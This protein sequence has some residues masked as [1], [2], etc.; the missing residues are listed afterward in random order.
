MDANQ[1]QPRIW[2]MQDMWYTTH[3]VPMFYLAKMEMFSTLAKNY[4]VIPTTNIS[5]VNS[6][7]DEG[8]AGL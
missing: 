1:R 8:D 7:G 2:N 4:F 6:Q 5:E 3:R